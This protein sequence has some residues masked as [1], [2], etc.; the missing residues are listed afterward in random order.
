MVNPHTPGV[1]IAALGSGTGKTTIATGLMAAL[2]KEVQVAA[3]KVGPDYIDPSYHGLATGRRGRNLDSVLC[4]RDLI[5]PLY[6]HGSSDC[7]MSV[8]E[9]VMGLFD[10]RI[11][12]D[13]AN[14]PAG[15]ELPHGSTA[16]IAA[17]LGMP[18]ILVVDVR[19]MSHTVGPMI[20][21][22]STTHPDVH[23]GGVI[24]N[25]VGSS[26]HAAVCT[27]AVQAYGIPVLGSIPRMDEV[28][29]PSRH[30][31]LITAGEL[32][33]AQEAVAVMGQ[34]VAAHIDLQQLREIAGYRGGFAPWDP[35]A[36]VHDGASSS[37]T[38]ASHPPGN[39][40]D[41]PVSIALAAGPAFSFTYVEH[42]ELLRACGAEVISFDPL[43]EPLPKCAG[44]IIPGGFPEEHV[45][46]LSQAPAKQAIS[47]AIT[48]GMPVHAECA[49]LLWLVE[50]LRG[51]TMLGVIPAQ[52]DMHRLTLGY[53]EAVAL[54]DS[55]VYHIGQRIHGHEFH[56][57]TLRPRAGAPALEHN[58]WGWRGWDHNLVREGFV[59][60]NVHASYL[61][62]HPAA[63][64]QA[65]QRFVAAARN[66]AAHNEIHG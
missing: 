44:L 47:Q 58:A 40:T 15:V 11:T 55:V 5:G 53:R 3:F 22:L 21:G 14:L 35:V 1:V 9:G 52:A 28:E 29:V 30:L 16:E 61:H 10:G 2:A 66:F 27:Q 31:G 65:C 50:S 34:L 13:D 26:R 7:D 60:P 63:Y 20:H 45:H 46:N 49:G 12:H 41:T 43:H 42:L 24:F 56:H 54:E 57:T 38:A 36:A 17:I 33:S 19:G 6:A 59:T 37:D 18:V 8:V 4:G 32:G 48:A 23:I 25:Q 64:P 51:A 39:D 62:V